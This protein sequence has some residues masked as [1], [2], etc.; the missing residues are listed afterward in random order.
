MHMRDWNRSWSRRVPQWFW[1]R[2]AEVHGPGGDYS[3]E[4]RELEAYQG[5]LLDHVGSITVDGD[6]VLVTQPYGGRQAMGVAFGFMRR[7]GL[8]AEIEVVAPWS[9]GDADSG[10][11]HT[12]LFMFRPDPNWRPPGD[13]EG[14]AQA[15]AD[16]QMWLF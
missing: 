7:Y 14:G 3:G 2:V 4:R 8:R 5:V 16:E 6:E 11:V 10:N 12:T 9:R 1:D 13:G 15:T